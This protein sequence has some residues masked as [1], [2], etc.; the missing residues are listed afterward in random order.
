MLDEREFLSPHGIRAVSRAHAEH[1]YALSLNGMDYRVG[2]EPGESSTGLF[3]GNS[4]WRGPIWFPANF[5]LVEALQKFH[6]YLG[7]GYK[8]ECPTGSGQMLTLHEV[9]E[10][11]SRRLSN[12]FLN[13]TS[14]RRPVFGGNDRFQS[15]PLWHDLVPFHEYFHGD[16]GAGLGASHQTGWTALVAKL[17][18]QSGE[19]ANESERRRTRHAQRRARRGARETVDV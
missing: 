9:A 7:D 4:N 11:I 15:D 12:I 1:P 14:G 16:S 3:G 2:Y 8:V 10:E 5:L 13:D 19:H 17:L 6:H 18:Q